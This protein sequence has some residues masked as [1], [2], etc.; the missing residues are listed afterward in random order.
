MAF[1][2]RPPCRELFPADA[3][4]PDNQGN[5]SRDAD[6]EQASTRNVKSVAFGPGR[7]GFLRNSHGSCDLGLSHGGGET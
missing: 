4:S 1:F 7:V 2:Q 5:A 6:A 3:H